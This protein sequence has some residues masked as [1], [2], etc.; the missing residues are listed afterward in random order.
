MSFGRFKIE[1]PNNEP[2]LEYAPGSWEREALRNE[3]EQQKRKTLDLPLVIGGKE[4]KT[5]EIIE[6]RAPHD[7]ELILG[8]ASLAQEEHVKKA[9]EIALESKEEWMEYAWDERAAIFLKAAELLSGPY[10]MKLNAATMLNLSK[11]P[12]Q[13]EIDTACELTDFFRFNSYFMYRIYKEQPFSPQTAFNRLEYRPLDGFIFAVTPFNFVSIMGNLPSAP[14]L[15]GNVVVWKPATSV[16]Y[17]AYQIM[18]L[19]QK[20]GLPDGV[21]N[22]I[23]GRSSLVGDLV[24]NHSDLGGIHFT[25]STE[26]FEY[27]WK[28]VGENIHKYNQYPR[29]VGETG[30]KDFIFIH[31]SADLSG[32]LAGLTR[33]A[34]EY[35]GQK[36]SAASRI[37]APK[38]LWP[39]IKKCLE[40]DL[41]QIKIGEPD[42]FSNF[43]NAVIDKKAF[44]RITEYIDFTKKSGEAEIILGGKTD[45]KKGFYIDPTVILAQKANYKT[46]TEEIFGPVLTIYLY[47]EEKFEETLHLCD[48][49]TQYALTGSIFAEDRKAISLATKILR[50]SAGNFYINV[51][52]TGA[53]VNQ[54]PFGG[55]RKSGTNDKAGSFLNLL[56]WVSPRSIK[57]RF[58][59]PRSYSYPFLLNEENEK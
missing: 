5:S 11:N 6:I 40:K 42:D 1:E 24:L 25:G 29:L 20:A 38:T 10:R 22:F 12:Y 36:C 17:I 9:M 15:M 35:Q 2:V 45:D 8:K 56:R 4:I 59:P 27:M 14:A 21:I 57:E 52:P 23:P 48:K 28:K 50:H 32:V 55:S 7:H 33:G 46:M 13:A 43:I 54:Q 44:T 39:P 19:F 34:F 58:Y 37:Y 53:V 30:G 31:K 16:I 51:K 3:I 49:S 18:K 26:T 41:S 47:D